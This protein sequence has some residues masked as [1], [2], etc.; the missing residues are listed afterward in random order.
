MTASVSSAGRI[1]MPSEHRPASA[2]LN[3]IWVS[4]PGSGGQ[5]TDTASTVTY[6]FPVPLGSKKFA[7]LK[8]TGP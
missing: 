7:R 3:G 5:V 2:T 1:G 6:T 4:E 8:V